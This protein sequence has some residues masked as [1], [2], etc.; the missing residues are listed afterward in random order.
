MSNM[1]SGQAGSTGDSLRGGHQSADDEGLVGDVCF[2]DGPK[3][4]LT[5]PQLRAIG[6]ALQATAHAV[7]ITSA[8]GRIQWVNHA[9]T[10]LTGYAAAEAIGQTPR[11]LKSG[12]H[13]AA[14][15]RELW[16]TILQGHV[17]RGE[18]TS[19]RKDGSLFTEEITITPVSEAGG[20]ITHFIGIEQDITARKQAEERLHLQAR[21][22]DS[23]GQAVIATDMNHRLIYWN[24]AAT[25]LFGWSRAEALGRPLA[26]VLPAQA[27]PEQQA[28]IMAMLSRGE[29]WSGEMSV[30][31]RDGG[32]VP[33]LT[34][35]SP[36][37]DEAGQPIAIIGV[38]VD[39]T[40]RKQIE[41]TIARLASFPELD[42]WPVVEM[43]ATG[44][45]QYMNPAARRLFP[46]LGL[47]GFRHPWLAGLETVASACAVGG[48]DAEFREVTI[49]HQTF[50]QLVYCVGEV[51][52]IRVYGLDITKRKRTEAALN[53]ALLQKEEALA[54]LDALFECA[55]L[56][57]GFWDTEL[58][59][60][61]INQALAAMNGLPVDAH[62][63]KTPGEL[64]PNLGD[65]QKLMGEWRQ[66]IETGE[67][68]VNVEIGGE[69]QACPGQMRW[70]SE[71]WFP[72]KV[73]GKTIGL[74]ASVLDITE[75][76]RAQEQLSRARDE[77]E[78]KV[79]ERTTELT[80]ANTAL[81][82]EIAERH[83]LEARLIG[84]TE[85]EQRRLGRD[86]H[87]GLCQQLAGIAYMCNSAQKRLVRAAPKEASNL[88]EI[89]ELIRAA[90]TQAHD[91]AH[92]LSPVSLQT[93]GLMAALETLVDGFQKIY[94]ITFRF[95]CQG[96]V[97]V[98]D[99][100][101][102]THLYR[103]A[104]EAMSNAA[105]HS[106]GTR[107]TLRLKQSRKV[108]TL[109]VK[110]NG[111][112]LPSRRSPAQGMGLEAMRFRASVI[113]ATLELRNDRRG[114]ALLT[115]S[116]PQDAKLNNQSAP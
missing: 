105:K 36:L 85:A 74:G 30:R 65:I 73:Q 5:G 31:R 15:Y 34:T 83:A 9:F 37:Y 60:Q 51:R 3:R 33:L 100:S 58:R 95:V 23:V 13:D 17:W 87:D 115:C 89:T 75:R 107:I 116:V 35:N 69:T 90:N 27:G 84:A 52:G 86:L 113:G 29:Q 20:R 22:L 66:V 32:V 91:I 1:T 6:A 101:V 76:R 81:Q 4:Q 41:A 7:L 72:V 92:G 93:N 25:R 79:L 44:G 62:L 42:P 10:Q 26:D 8:D 67:P 48:S 12:Q 94:P 19:K 109:T 108:I 56:G 21:M 71:N 102:A 2:R 97:L 38:G 28:R 57:L 18:I 78:Q 53:L 14:F 104:Q 77:L 63:G 111:T 59:Y 39:L 82:K 49:G 16:A 61:R 43:D 88:S 54:R 98:R 68:R 96:K 40:E 45:L 46:D 70:R 110:D 24:A 47:H 112:G 99:H 80:L 64:L 55:P 114:G 103:I 106:K 50:Q 11:L